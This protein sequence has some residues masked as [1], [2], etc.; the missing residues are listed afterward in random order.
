MNTD[1]HRG[2]TNLHKLNAK[3]QRSKG[4]R[5][6]LTEENG[7]NEGFTFFASQLRRG[8]EAGQRRN[9]DARAHLFCYSAKA[10]KITRRACLS[11]QKGLTR[12][13]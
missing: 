3:A 11:N 12:L 8:N 7:G 2:D 10:L 6:F 1:K 5:R 4:A 13:A 9:D